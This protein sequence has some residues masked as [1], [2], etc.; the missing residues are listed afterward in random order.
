MNQMSS[1]SSL[2]IYSKAEFASFLD[3]VDNDFKGT[4]NTDELK[5]YGEELLFNQPLAFKLLDVSGTINAFKVNFQSKISN[6]QELDEFIKC[7]ES[8]NNVTLRIATNKTNQLTQRSKY[9]EVRYYR[10][11]HNTRC[12]L[13]RDVKSIKMKNP[14]KRQK[15]TNCPFT[16][17]IKIVKETLIIIDQDALVKY[18]GITIMRLNRCRLGGLKTFRKII[19]WWYDTWNCI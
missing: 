6:S 14:S 12:V 15:N 9:C 3:N 1:I 8:T 18:S 7:F 10:C 13:T 5:S 17:H 16:L 19:Y 11:Q 4:S 2:P